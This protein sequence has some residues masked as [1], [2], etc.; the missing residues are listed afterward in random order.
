MYNFFQGAH[1]NNL[2]KRYGSPTV[3][4]NLVKKRERKI[5]ESQLSDHLVSAV[6]YLNKFLPPCRHI[7]YIHFDM[8]KMNKRLIFIKFLVKFIFKNLYFLLVRMSM[9]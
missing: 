5:H 2:Y 7:Q 3:I 8:A 6:K 9:L 1:F 4:I